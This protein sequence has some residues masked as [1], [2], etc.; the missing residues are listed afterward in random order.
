[1]RSNSWRAIPLASGL[2]FLLLLTGP[3]QKAPVVWSA[4]P[5]A[6]LPPGIQVV[7]DLGKASRETTPTRERVCQN[8]LW[9]WQPAKETAGSVPA[10]GWGYFK[11]PG[12]WPGTSNYAQEDCQTLHAHPAWKDTDVRRLTAAWYQREMTVPE[13]W[14]GRRI[15]LSAEYVN[16]FAVVHVDGK[17]VG[18]VRFPSGEVDLTAVCRPGR[19]YV[20]SLLVVAMPLKGVL[21]SYTDT[22]AAREVK[23]TVER[24]GL[25]GDVYLTSTPAAERL[26]DLKIDTSVRKGAVTFNAA[27]EGLA[28]DG[29]YALRVEVRDNDRVVREVTSKLFKASDLKGGRIAFTEKWQP[30]KLWDVHTPE[31]MLSARVSLVGGGDK[32]LDAFSPV[33]FGFREVWI[34]GRD[35]HLN[36]TRIDLPAG[37]L[38]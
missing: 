29:R 2:T 28:A 5:D 18:E 36:G 14:A 17:K 12:F 9:R 20:V 19:K 3:G 23:G 10:D 34:D 1:M 16:A 8:G 27:L 37:T 11:V 30:E 22:N 26:V 38:I 24:R 7:W 32:L 25:C 35:S 13:G 6:P 21:L 4:P 15:A 33:R 31:N